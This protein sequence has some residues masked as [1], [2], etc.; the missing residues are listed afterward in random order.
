MKSSFV[1]VTTLLSLAG[2]SLVSCQQQNQ[3]PK[4]P[5]Y[6]FY[7]INDGTGVNVVLGQEI[8]QAELQGRLG[9][10]ETC[11]TQFPVVGVSTTFST[12]SD[13]TD[14]AASG[15]ALATGHKTYNGAL[16][17]DAD[18]VAVPSIAEWAHA[19][20]YPVGVATSVN[21]N[22]ATPGAFY[23]HV[24]DRNMYYEVAQQLPA[25]GYDFFGGS[26]INLQRSKNTPEVREELYKVF[27]DSGYVIARGSYADYEQKVAEGAEKM[28]LFQDMDVVLNGG[29]YS[30]PYNID[31][32]QGMLSVY[33]V[34]RAE[35][36]F[37]Y[38]RSE[39]K[40]GKGFFLMNEIG[41]KIDMACHANDAATAFSEVAMADSCVKVAYN[42]YLQ[43]PDETLI[44]ITSDHETGGMALGNNFGGYATNFKLL[45]NQKCSVDELTHH[46]QMLRSASH[47][48]VTWE[49][50][51]EQLRNDVGF[52]EGVSLTVEEENMLKD[53]YVKSFVGQMENE[54]NLYSANEPMAAAA[55]RLMNTKAF[56]GW[57][58]GAHTAGLVA[59][60][61]IGV[62]AEKFMGHNDNADIPMKIAEIAGYRASEAK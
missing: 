62:G 56:V 15:T 8:Y 48:K 2:L 25:T 27:A 61:A 55:I 33:D 31:A 11:M 4:Q 1:L 57:T 39:Q 45:A 10:Q 5:K 40:G 24:Q 30:F 54:K 49:Q 35:T 23:A 3:Q 47:N 44:V 28:M 19:M 29:A 43:H 18:T 6:V 46:F 13:V 12:S 14:S 42:F 41:G 37:L 38:R 51:K 32:Q 21:V 20:G 52:W 59:V 60:Y 53:L 9:R 50:V 36:D 26:D 34:M 7:L 17:V 16:G 22:H 58:S